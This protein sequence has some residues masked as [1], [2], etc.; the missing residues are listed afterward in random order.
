[1]KTKFYLAIIIFFIAEKTNAQANQQL[2]NLIAP[3]AV[4]V[5][6][7]PAIDNNTDLGSSGKKLEEHIFSGCTIQDLLHKM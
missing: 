4:N 3:T 5:K 7:L 2:S 1:M 6:L